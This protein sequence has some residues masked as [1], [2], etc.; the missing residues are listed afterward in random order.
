MACEACG[1]QAN[2]ARAMDLS[3]AMVNQMFKGIRQLPM[4]HGA[5]IEKASNFRV[6][7]WD[8]FPNDWFRVWPELIGA[9]G[10]PAIPE[11]APV[12]EGA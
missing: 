7:R 12:T 1:S 11:T 10:A 2:L 9:K 4:E 3:P 5:A 8:F 6:M